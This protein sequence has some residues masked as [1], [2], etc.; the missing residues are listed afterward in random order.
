MTSPAPAARVDVRRADE[1]YSTRTSWLDSRHSFSFG[2]HYDPAN[3]RHGLL[4]AHNDDRVQPGAGFPEHPHRDLEIVTW[5]VQGLLVHRD[6]TGRSGVAHPGRVQR[7]SAGRGVVHS[8]SNDA[9]RLQDDC[10][11]EPVHYVQMW[12]LPEEP[13]GDPAY[14]QLDVDDELRSGRLVPVVSGRPGHEGGGLRLRTREAALHAARLRPGR[15]VQ[16]P[17]APYLHLFVA[18]GAVDLE[19]AGALSAGDAVRLTA[20]GGHRVTS[21][22]PAEVLVWEMHATPDG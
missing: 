22:G 17:E 12:V 4:L 1:R 21:A 11:P 14:E 18:T 16:L 20:T 3:I 15:S 19:G 9:Y 8:E 10:P 13:G 5:V 2:G 6:S 7:L